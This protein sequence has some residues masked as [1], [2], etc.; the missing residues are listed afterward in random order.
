[1]PIH[2]TDS[3]MTSDVSPEYAFR[4]DFGGRKP[5]RLSWWRDRPLTADQARAGMEL[6]EL[7][8]DPALV[9]DPMA[10]ALMQERAH[11]VGLVFAQAV[12]LLAKAMAARAVHGV[13]EIAPGEPAEGARGGDTGIPRRPRAHGPSHGLEY[14]TDRCR[15]HTEPPVV[16]P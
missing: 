4:V 8:S 5:W 13:V 12:L 11:R 3:R 7:V 2:I 6:D 1:M 16:F 15:P 14:F 10:F 9:D